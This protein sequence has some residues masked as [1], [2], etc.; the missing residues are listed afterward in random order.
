M[1]S[2]PNTVKAQLQSL[3]ELANSKTGKS[4]VDLTG[5]VNTLVSERDSLID[6]SITEV[7]SEA[8]AVGAMGLANKPNLIT[9][10]LPN[11][12][13]IGY[14]GISYNSSL[15]N[16]NMP[17]AR[18]FGSH[19]FYQ[20][21]SLENINLPSAAYVGSNQFNG[22]SSLKLVYV[23][24]DG[25]GTNSFANCIELKALIIRR[26]NH[27]SA[28][29]N[30]NLFNNTPIASGTGFIYVPRIKI[31][32]YKI[33]TNWVTYASQFRALEDYTVDGT[34][35]GELDWDKVNGGTL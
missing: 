9:V 12:T 28:A 19:G 33:A 3:I 22:C 26:T 6:G 16:V 7:Y 27:V 29:T 31:E 2:T 8:E 34:V 17:K 4:D 5:A 30:S 15:K 18:T 13:D 10:I 21:I 23:S 11:A 35:D 14:S 1:S 32:D 20:D 25:F 24:P